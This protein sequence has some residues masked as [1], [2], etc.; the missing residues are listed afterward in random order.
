MC[1]FICMSTITDIADSWNIAIFLYIHEDN[2]P[3]LSG[4]DQTSKRYD[5]LDGL[6]NMDFSKIENKLSSIFS[7]VDGNNAVIIG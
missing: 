1:I 2:C 3:K 4:T 6:N 5:A 7:D